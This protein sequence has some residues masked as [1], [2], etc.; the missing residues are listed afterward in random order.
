M[1]AVA[2]GALA[3]VFVDDEGGGEMVTRSTA[4]ADNNE[5]GAKII[6]LR[7]G[8]EYAAIMDDPWCHIYVD[9]TRSKPVIAITGEIDS[10]S[11]PSLQAAIAAALAAK[12]DRVLIDATSAEFISVGGYCTI[13]E[14][15]ESVSRV[16]LCSRSGLAARVMD[17]LGFPDVVCVVRQP[18]DAVSLLLP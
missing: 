17:I 16:T 13:G 1:G 3:L 7:R 8:V 15:S 6:P 11:M 10:V 9:A 12:P 2:S 4:V 18:T 14:L 5:A